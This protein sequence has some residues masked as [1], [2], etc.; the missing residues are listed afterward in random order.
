VELAKKVNISEEHFQRWLKLFE[1]EA[2][3]A[4]PPEAAVEIINRAHSIAIVLRRGM[5]VDNGG[6]QSL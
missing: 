1:E 3:K 4:L 5:G 6:L 2:S